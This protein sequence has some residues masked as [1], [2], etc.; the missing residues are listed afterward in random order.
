L[1]WLLPLP[2]ALI[3]SLL[4]VASLL[5]QLCCRF[6]FRPAAHAPAFAGRVLGKLRDGLL[7]TLLR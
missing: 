6:Y 7:V 1:S 5:I 2:A 3:A 4:L